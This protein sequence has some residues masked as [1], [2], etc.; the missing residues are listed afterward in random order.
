VSAS[1]ITVATILVTEG[2]QRSSLAAII[3]TTGALALTGLLG[4][5]VTGMM[6]FAY[7]AG[8]DLAFATTPDGTGLDLGGLLLAAFIL[9]AVGVLDDVTVT[10]AVL[11]DELASQGRLQGRDLFGS[12]MGVGRSHIGATVNTLFLA[13]VGA[14]LPLLVLLL[15]SRQPPALVLNGEATSTEIVRTLVGSIGIVAAVPFTTFVAVLLATGFAANEPRGTT[16]VVAL[17]ALVT[18]I[19]GLLLATMLLPLTTGPVKPLPPLAVGPDASFSTASP[20]TLPNPTE[21]PAE[22]TDTSPP[23]EPV[24]AVRGEPLPLV[25]DGGYVGTVTVVDWTLAP[26]APPGTGDHFRAVVRFVA[27]AELD[28]SSG[29]WAL[30][31]D[32]G[33]EIGLT[34]EDSPGLDGALAPG[35]T[36]DVAVEG[37]LETPTSPPFLVYID[38]ASAAIVYAIA[39]E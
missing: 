20:Q 37:D 11:V 31:L 26:A 19:G 8:S 9:G 3:G 39:I 30:L 17:I 21:E 28:P 15:I 32:D 12:A 25:E 35:E 38:L 23:D 5:V 29:I 22:S 7:T 10:Q 14:G 34:S 24:L 18:T 13:Y 36:R 6:G 2:W 27:S 4:A 16:R 33:T 1:V